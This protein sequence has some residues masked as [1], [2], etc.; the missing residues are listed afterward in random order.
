MKGQE[1]ILEFHVVNEYKSHLGCAKSQKVT[2]YYF[3][4]IWMTNQEIL[5]R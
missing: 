2:V 4:Y 3:Y 5:H 1:E